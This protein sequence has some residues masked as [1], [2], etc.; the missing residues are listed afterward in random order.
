[1]EV[2]LCKTLIVVENSIM[3]VNCFTNTPNTSFVLH[4]ITPVQDIL[5]LAKLS[6]LFQEPFPKPCMLFND[7]QTVENIVQQ[8]V[9]IN[10]MKH[11]KGLALF[12][13]KFADVK[14][15]FIMECIQLNI[16]QLQ[17]VKSQDNLADLMMKPVP[18][19]I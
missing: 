9:H 6:N 12:N 15:H 7:N 11:I 14:Y 2:A 1:M 8:K 3:F 16:I 10:K 19:C 4:Q 18:K 13:K 17:Y 5:W